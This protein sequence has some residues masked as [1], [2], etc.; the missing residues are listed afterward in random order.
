MDGHRR[1]HRVLTTAR[2]ID[3]QLRAAFG[4]IGGVDLAAEIL[5]D[6]IGD[7]QAET[8]ALADRLGGEERIENLI[9]EVRRNARSSYRRR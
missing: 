1:R 8:E 2:E 6:A 9:D 7:R 3:G 4:P 5:H